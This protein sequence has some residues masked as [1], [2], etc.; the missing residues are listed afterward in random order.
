MVNTDSCVPLF[1]KRKDYFLI[2][3]NS[4]FLIDYWA[5]G[6]FWDQMI[7]N[8]G[9]EQHAGRALFYLQKWVAINS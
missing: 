9:K 6:Y 7:P 2:P 3:F 1:C 8:S 5:M 4:L